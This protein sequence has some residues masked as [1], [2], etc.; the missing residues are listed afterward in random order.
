MAAKV[1]KQLIDK[2][3]ALIISE[4]KVSYEFLQKN[5]GISAGF[6]V[7]LLAALAKNKVVVQGERRRWFVIMNPDG[8]P[9]EDAPPQKRFAK[10]RRKEP[11]QQNGAHEDAAARIQFVQNLAEVAEGKNARVLRDVVKDLMLLNKHRK[12]FDALH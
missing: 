7:R 4:Q 11:E 8:S 6:A 2:A 1:T 12:F 9:K 3:T 10:A 5:L